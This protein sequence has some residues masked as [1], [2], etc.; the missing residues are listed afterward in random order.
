MQNITEEIIHQPNM[1][2][3]SRNPGNQMPSGGTFGQ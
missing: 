2:S 3:D 1:V